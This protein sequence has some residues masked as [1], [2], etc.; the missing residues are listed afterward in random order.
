MSPYY[1]YR[2][3]RC[4]ATRE[5]SQSITDDR[6]IKCECGYWMEREIPRT[7]LVFKGEGWA[8]KERKGGKNEAQS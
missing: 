6:L 4:K 3:A 1:D 7:S 5:I 8:K 2:C